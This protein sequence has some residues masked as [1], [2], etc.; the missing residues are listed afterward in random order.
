MHRSSALV[1]LVLLGAS[2]VCLALAPLALPDSYDVVRHALTRAGAQGVPGAW[3][4]R[5]GYALLGVAVLLEAARAGD[6]WGPVGRGG[7]AVFG[8]AM[9]ALAVFS[10]SPWY[11]GAG[12]RVE[13]GLHTWAATTAVL[14]FFVGVLGVRIRRGTRP[15]RIAVLDVVALAGVPVLALAAETMPG[16][17]GV[18]ERLLFA[19]GFAWYATEAV[20]LARPDGPGRVREL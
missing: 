3:V 9:V 16:G 5:T 17:A 6:A 19:I 18:T 7:H 10:A 15:G 20:R 14:A 8:T 13:A 1:V 12:D 2:A 11:G 4:A